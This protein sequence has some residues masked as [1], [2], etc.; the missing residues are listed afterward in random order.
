[1]DLQNFFGMPAMAQWRNR[2][3]AAI[4]PSPGISRNRALPTYA[5]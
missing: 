5:S 3:R 1:V 4:D 2:L